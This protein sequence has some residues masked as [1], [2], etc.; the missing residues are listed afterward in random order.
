MTRGKAEGSLM[1]LLAPVKGEPL[2]QGLCQSHTAGGQETSNPEQCSPVLF[3]VERVYRDG[4][5]LSTREKKSVLRRE[6]GPSSPCS[7]LP[8]IDSAFAAHP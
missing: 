8:G 7:Y 1:W 2:R 4:K 5:P 6:E 3:G